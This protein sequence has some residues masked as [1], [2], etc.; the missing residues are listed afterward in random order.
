M[1]LQKI[2]PNQRGVSQATAV[3]QSNLGFF[4]GL[5]HHAF[6]DFAK[7]RLIVAMRSTFC[8]IRTGLPSEFS[9]TKLTHHRTE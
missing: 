7:V 3:N 2:A 9:A 4:I 1:A 6:L 8:S 5:H